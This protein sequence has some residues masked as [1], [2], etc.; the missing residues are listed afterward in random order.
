MIACKLSILSV[1]WRKPQ[2]NVQAAKQKGEGKELE[3]A[4][5]PVGF[6]FT[7]RW[8]KW[9]TIGKKMKSC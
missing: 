7:F 3:L 1:K 4:M 2:K 6:L 9:N 5:I 8:A